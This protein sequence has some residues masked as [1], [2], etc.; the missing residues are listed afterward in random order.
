MSLTL[1][2]ELTARVALAALEVALAVA[3]VVLAV[4]DDAALA[5]AK[6]ICDIG[7]KGV[8]KR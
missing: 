6:K 4:V 5:A 2:L 3:E 7:K 8:V 1:R